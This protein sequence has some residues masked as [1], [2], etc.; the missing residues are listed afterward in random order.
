M[1][2]PALKEAIK[3]L[4]FSLLSK[5]G[6]NEELAKWIINFITK[7]ENCIRAVVEIQLSEHFGDH[8]NKVINA[9]TYGW[10]NFLPIGRLPLS[11]AP[12][13]VIVTTYKVT[14]ENKELM[15]FYSAAYGRLFAGTSIAAIASAY[16]EFGKEEETLLICSLPDFLNVLEHNKIYVFRN[17]IPDQYLTN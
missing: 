7:P 10:E 11:V 17:L 9:A 8:Q 15:V 6:I 16:N 1:R 5:D 4:T 14:K 3:L 12:T 13:D 2:T